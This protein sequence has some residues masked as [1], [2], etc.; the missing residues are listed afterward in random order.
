M[1]TSRVMRWRNYMN[2]YDIDLQHIAGEENKLADIFSRLPRMDKISVGN[3]EIEMIRK[4]KGKLIDF[5]SL[6]PTIDEDDEEVFLLSNE[7]PR[8]ED[9]YNE[10]HSCI[11]QPEL[12]PTVCS[13]DD[14]LTIE[15]LLNMDECFMDTE[16]CLLNLPS[17]KGRKNPLTMINI[18]NHQRMDQDLINRA[19]NSSRYMSQNVNGT[20]ILCYQRNP[21]EN[22]KI[23]LP[24]SLVHDTIVWYHLMLGHCGK[25]RLYD[26]LNAR[27]H[28]PGLSAS[29]NAY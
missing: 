13:N 16:E 25:E 6:K 20:N 12:F 1:S 26:T 17:F 7:R 11:E 10:T 28:H 22:W 3:D 27:F 23:C 9:Y 15:C 8:Q 19:R 5:K 29:C 24:L 21:N 18:L 4:K 14:C 2:D